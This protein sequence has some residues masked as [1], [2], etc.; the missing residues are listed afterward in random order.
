[1]TVPFPESPPQLVATLKAATHPLIQVNALEGLLDKIRT[2]KKM[3]LPDEI[4]TRILIT[5]TPDLTSKN[6]RVRETTAQ[7]DY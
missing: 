6:L 7:H 3:D 5:M 4:N 2:P 1:M